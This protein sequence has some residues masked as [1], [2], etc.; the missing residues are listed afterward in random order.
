MCICIRVSNYE[1]LGQPLFTHFQTFCF[2][3][4]IDAQE[5]AKIV[6][7]S[8]VPFS[9]LLPV[10]PSY[11]TIVHYQSR[12]STLAQCINRLQTLN[13]ASCYLHSC[14][15]IVLYNFVIC[16]LQDTNC[17]L[18]SREPFCATSLL[19]L[20]SPPPTLG[21]HSFVPHFFNFLLFRMLD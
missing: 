19:S 1:L 14:M 2:E 6:Q 16:M 21:N 12:K 4:I 10:V 3:I 11:I 15:C 8:H 7:R 9:Q 20:F 18:I 17:L 5:V 13:F